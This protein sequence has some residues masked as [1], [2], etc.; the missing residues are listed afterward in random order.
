VNWSK[1]DTAHVTQT[2][3]TSQASVLVP[4]FYGISFL[5]DMVDAEMA[6]LSQLGRSGFNID[7]R[8]Q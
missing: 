1:H 5:I 8:W 2:A 4:G 3:F 6:L 7:I